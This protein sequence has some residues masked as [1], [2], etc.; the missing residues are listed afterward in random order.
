MASLALDK[1]GQMGWGG[2]QGKAAV[3]DPAS[4]GLRSALVGGREPARIRTLALA[5][6]AHTIDAELNRNSAF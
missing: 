3:L 4:G 2:G 6:T 5:R 1:R